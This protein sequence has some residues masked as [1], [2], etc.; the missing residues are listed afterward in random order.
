MSA[1]RIL[2]VNPCSVYSVQ[3]FEKR[4][5]CLRPKLKGCKGAGLENQ[6]L[7]GR[8]EID[9]NQPSGHTADAAL[10]IVTGSKDNVVG[11]YWIGFFGFDQRRACAANRVC[12]GLE[13]P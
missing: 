6:N 4:K 3:E 7:P 11:I 9:L 1:G 10:G 2:S 8:G 12:S 5:K 13:R